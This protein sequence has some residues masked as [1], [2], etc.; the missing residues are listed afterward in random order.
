MN[1]RKMLLLMIIMIFSSDLTYASDISDESLKQPIEQLNETNKSEKQPPE[2]KPFEIN[3]NGPSI[4]PMNIKDAT[5]GGKDP[6]DFVWSKVL[7]F[8]AWAKGIVSRILPALP[9]VYGIALI[10][11]T[12]LGFVISKKIIKWVLL[13]IASS[14]AGVLL[15]MNGYEWWQAIVNWLSS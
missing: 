1:I 15:I 5:I 11:G 14:L 4:D 6:L 13:S 3:I 7:D 2:L 10:V 8:W 12:I 9:A